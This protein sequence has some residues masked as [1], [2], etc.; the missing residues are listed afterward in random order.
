M[1]SRRHIVLLEPYYGG[2]HAVFAD[3]WRHH[4]AHQITLVTLPARKWKWRMRGAAMW[5][6]REGGEW[7]DE[8]LSPPFDAIFCTDMLSVAD[9]RALLPARLRNTPIACYFHE[10]QLTYPIPHERDRDYQY[11]MTNIT[12]CLAADAV[13]FNSNFHRRDF[14]RAADALLRKMPDYVPDALIDSLRDTS[15]VIY[16]PVDV[17]SNQAQ[18]LNP[19]DPSN[20]ASPKR[21]IRFLWPHRW[22]Y[23]KHPELLF[24][25]FGRLH[26]EGH[27]FEIVLLGEQFRT[28]PPVFAQMLAQLDKHLVQVGFIPDRQDY[29]K[30]LS[31][32]DVV[33]STAIQENFGIAVVEAMLCGCQPILPNR[34]A[35]PELIPEDFHA[36]CLY[37]DDAALYGRLLDLIEHGTGL[38]AHA[39]Q[40]L[41]KSL[42]DRFGLPVA[43]QRLDSQMTELIESVAHV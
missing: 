22:E 33:V 43:I 28:A 1:D 42:S 31:H 16:P 21:P 41:R 30:M 37:E 3:T 38:T 13:W 5:F 24:E 9:L 27:E 40:Q 36:L 2:S 25:A 6:V 39:Q 35:Y 20:E 32:C 11:G 7:L 23:D 29:L 4:S 17:S 26:Q 8:T 18:T 10:N 19:A 15:S 12:S 14:L 34:L